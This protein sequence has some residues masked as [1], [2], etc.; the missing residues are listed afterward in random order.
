MTST[1]RPTPRLRRLVPV[2][3]VSAG[4]VLA[5]GC[6]VMS[7]VATNAPYVAADGVPVDLGGV[8]VRNLVVVSDA[9]GDP[10]VVT[11]AVRNDGPS[12]QT[13]TF[14][15]ESGSSTQVKVP[16]YQ[17][18]SL[19]V[20]D[21]QVQLADVPTAPGALV[22]MQVSTPAHGIDVVRV[23]VLPARSYYSSLSPTSTSTP[24][25][26]PASGSPGS[27]SS[28][29]KSSGSKP[30]GSKSSGSTSST[31]KSSGSKSSG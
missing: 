11:A 12:A 22:T 8:K 13:V 3:A 6:Q 21:G 30:S 27:S 2:L 20:G 26:P 18:V 14:A 28:S 10:G 29:T 1:A 9:K 4:V 25:T 16:A 17:E 15:F 7:P 5:S 23:P 31:A 24:T 19:S